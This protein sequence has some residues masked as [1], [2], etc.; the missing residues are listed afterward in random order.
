MVRT[1]RQAQSEEKNGEVKSDEAGQMATHD[2]SQ[3]HE[4]TPRKRKARGNVEPHSEEQEQGNSKAVKRNSNGKKTLSTGDAD[5][6]QSEEEKK[7][8]DSSSRDNDLIAQKI[9]DLIAKYGHFPLSDVGLESPDEATPET[10]LA[11]VM[12]VLLLSVRI[13]HRLA[14]RALRGLVSQRY[15]DLKKLK[16]S[17][18]GERVVILDDSGYA[19]YDHRAATELGQLADL[20]ETKYGTLFCASDSF[21]C[22]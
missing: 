14:R 17:T 1:R 2:D 20:I 5:I 9:E 7:E 13:S 16:A 15:H 3:Q 11:H 12:N 21:T 8:Y 22:S 4:T 10:I 6:L 19:R 18:W